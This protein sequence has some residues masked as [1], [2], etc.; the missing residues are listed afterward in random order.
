MVTWLGE[1]R[2][3]IKVL[4]FGMARLLVGGPRHAPH[5]KGAVFGTLE[6]MP[7]EQAMGQPV[8]AR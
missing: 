3:W 5:V 1:G 8:D 7:P 4:D 2:P 6:Y